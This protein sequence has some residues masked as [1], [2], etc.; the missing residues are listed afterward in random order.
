[1]TTL[2]LRPLAGIC[3]TSTSATST[4]RHLLLPTRSD[5]PRTRG[6]TDRPARFGGPVQLYRL[7]NA[8]RPVDR[9]GICLSGA[10]Q[11][12]TLRYG[13]SALLGGAIRTGGRLR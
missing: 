6:M 10:S 5:D 4:T 3:L 13:R 8:R 1:M 12:A 2:T 9:R 7:R 11:P